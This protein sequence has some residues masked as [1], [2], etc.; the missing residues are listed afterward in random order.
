MH[1]SGAQMDTNKIK[2]MLIILL[3]GAE[4]RSHVTKQDIGRIYP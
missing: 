3:T 1:V 2:M 4:T